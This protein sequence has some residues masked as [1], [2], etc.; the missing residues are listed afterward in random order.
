M[1][2]FRSPR[3]AVCSILLL[4]SS[5][6][7]TAQPAPHEPG[8][9]RARAA[10][11]A[12]R[13]SALRYALDFELIPHA[14]AITGHETLTFNDTGAGDLTL[15]FRDG[16]VSAATLN[17]HAIPT[18]LDNGHLNLHTF[19]PDSHE[20]TFPHEESLAEPPSGSSGKPIFVGR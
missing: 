10:S 18:A 3:A 19:A 5:V 12:A 2:L 4:V 7:C 13:L 14:A 16:A 8:V 20:I 15:D 1:S 17:G 9:S 11:R 6:V